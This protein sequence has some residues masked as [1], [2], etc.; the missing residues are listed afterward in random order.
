V[1]QTSER[2]V[3]RRGKDEILLR[4][5]NGKK[6]KISQHTTLNPSPLVPYTSKV[7][8]CIN[9]LPIHEERLVGD[10]PA[11]WTPAGWDPTTPVNI[12]IA[13]DGSVNFGV[14]Y[15]IWVVATEDEDILLQGGGPDDGDLF[16]IQLYRSELGGDSGPCSPRYYQ[17]VQTHQHSISYVSV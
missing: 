9:E 4:G 2:I 1:R 15:H 3:C 6:I 8:T 5:N 12:I 14:G 10:I 16:L 7:G 17:Q 11:L 13:T